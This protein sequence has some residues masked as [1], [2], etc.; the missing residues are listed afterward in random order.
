MMTEAVKRYRAK[1]RAKMNEIAKRYYENNKQKVLDRNKAYL[2]QN[3]E[4]VET[5]RKEY[6][7]ENQPKIT[8]S[9]RKQSLE[10]RKRDPLYRVTINLRARLRL[11][12]NGKNKSKKT[13]ELLGCS[14]E[15]LRNH[16]ESK[17]TEGMTWENYGKWHID[18]IKPCSSFDLLLAENQS[19]CFHYS[20]LQPLWAI[21]NLKKY[22]K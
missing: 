16:L 17:F 10:R 21:D 1:N 19:L 14:V 5:R 3:K 7:K 22:N 11:A 15:Y 6:R 8:E 13:L 2:D 12:L 20:N 9:K 18:H 4:K